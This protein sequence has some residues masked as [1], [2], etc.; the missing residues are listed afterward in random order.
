MPAHLKERMDRWYLLVRWA[1]FIYGYYGAPIYLVGSA[2]RD[3]NADPRDWDIRCRLS[4]E[5]FRAM[6]GEP[7]EWMDEQ[8][9]GIWTRVSFRWSDEMVKRTQNGWRHTKLNIDFQA[10]PPDKWRQF[11]LAARLRLD[12]RDRCR[13]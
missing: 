6:F 3:D 11:T 1:N 4:N 13:K 9:S 12:T 2:L 7:A 8:R 10:Y 5:R